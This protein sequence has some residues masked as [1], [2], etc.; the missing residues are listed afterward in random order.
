MESAAEPDGD[1]HDA[2]YHPAVETSVA[3][4]P[5][6]QDDLWLFERLATDPDAGGPFNWSG[7]KGVTAIRHQFD[8]NGLIGADGGRLIVTNEETVIGNVAWNRVAYGTPEWSCWNIGISLLPEHRYQGFG[9]K[10][11]F[12][13]VAYLFNTRPVERI[14]AY[15]D[16][17]NVVEQ[18]ALA[19]VGFTKEGVL[20][21]VQF[22]DGR[23][24]DVL[25]YSIL[26]QEFAS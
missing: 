13:L 6:C 7:Y 21:A 3:L 25:M 22:R 15:T 19:T 16:V 20:R 5:A 8:E 11:H 14:E 1:V 17:E 26:R 10:A 23:W 4:R 9:T 12:L 24:R 18:R 2:T